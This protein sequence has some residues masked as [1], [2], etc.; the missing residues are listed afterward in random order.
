MEK[1]ARVSLLVEA[2]TLIT[3]PYFVDET[4]DPGPAPTPLK[5]FSGTT[6]YVIRTGK[7]FHFAREFE[8]L[9]KAGEMKLVG[10]ASVDGAGVPLKIEGKVLGVF[11]VQSYTPGIEYAPRPTER[12][13]GDDG[14]QIEGFVEDFD[15]GE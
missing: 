15:A 7:A 8:Q 1:L 10:P 9:A 13:D 3:W 14:V 12:A 4:G 11:A 6:A 2:P 5:E